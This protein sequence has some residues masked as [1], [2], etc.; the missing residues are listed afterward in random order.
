MQTIGD[1]Y[2]HNEKDLYS[3]NVLQGSMD[4]ESTEIIDVYMEPLYETFFCPLTNKIM[5]DPV[6]IETGITYERDAITEWCKKFG[7]PADIICPKTGVKITNQV[8]NRNIAL[9]ETIKKWEERN[10]QAIIRAAKSTLSLV[11]NKTMILEA[12]HNLQTLCR[13]KQYNVVEIRTIGVIPLLGRILGHEDKDVI[14][15][16]LELLKKLAENVDDD[17]DDDGKEMIV[18]TMDLSVIIQNLSSEVE[19]IRHAALLLLVDLSKS[20][21]F[22]DK[23]GSVT[24]G[25]LMLITLKYRQPIDELALEKIDE[26]LKNLERS[27][28]N[29][30]CMAENG[31]W[32]P[33]LHHFLEG[34]EETKMEMA[35]FIGEIFLGN[36]DDNNTYVAE[37]ASHALIEMVFQGNS[38][39]RNVAFKALKQISSHHENGKILVKSGAITNM[40]HEMF[41]RTI[42]NEPTNS[43][44]EAA[45]ILANIL[46]SGEVDLTDLQ[47]DHTMSLDYIIYNFVKGVSNSTPDEL[48]I[49]FVRILLCLMKFP[50][51]SDIIVSLV[52]ESDLCTNLIELLNNP[53]AKLQISSILFSISLSP[54][55]GHTLAE[56][57]CKTRGQPQNLLKD[58]PRTM[59]PTKKQAVSVKFLATL[60][61]ENLTLNLALLNMDIVPLILT[62]IDRVQK[63]GMRIN[64]YGSDYFEGLVG[65]L[66]RFTSTLYEQQFLILAMNFSFTRTFTELLMNTSDEVQR[67][68]AIGLQNLSSKTVSLSKPTDIKEHKLRKFS[69]LQK[70][71]PFNSRKLKTTPMYMCPIHKGACS[72]QETFCLLEANAIQKLLT[73]FDHKNVDVV[74]AALSAICTLLDERVDLETSVSILIHEKAIQHV[75]NVVKEHKDESLRQKSFWILEKML[76]KGDDN[77]TSEISQDRFFRAMLITTLHH[78]HAD[79]KLMAERILRHLNT[80]PNFNT[81]FTM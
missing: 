79:I 6:T 72:S 7:D 5:D 38:L 25:F 28:S 59:P 53:S 64:K 4:H 78:G 10:E 26:I 3:I 42:Y 58:L 55:F 34:D 13:K 76:M 65:I 77:S 74:E 60:P 16:T 47:V 15:E 48:S 62:E 18:K 2:V 39:A 43:K 37:T 57:L 51:T 68:S 52:K 66:V 1:I 54:F 14:F 20:G 36:D 27:S 9:M 12:L 50:K 75:L 17:D 35:S 46:E 33:L 80:R 56:R 63:S 81:N 30:K 67:L 70:C 61:H 44:A 41:K 49:N 21:D 11:S 71:F 45:G 32:Q 69:F 8:F 19:C 29:I 40:L 24:G 73:C 31:H 22:C 23:F